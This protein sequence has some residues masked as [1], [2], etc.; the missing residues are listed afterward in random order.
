MAHATR[1]LALLL[2]AVM[3]LGGCSATGLNQ[4]DPSPKLE[5]ASTTTR[6]PANDVLTGK[7]EEAPC[8]VTGFVVARSPQ[9]IVVAGGHLETDPL[10]SDNPHTYGYARGDATT[11][12]FCVF[13]IDGDTPCETEGGDPLPINQVEPGDTVTVRW[14]GPMDYDDPTYRYPERLQI[15]DLVVRLDPQPA[16]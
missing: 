4:A 16:S 10:L 8:V 7:D 12:D 15:P 13:A 2:A 11:P 6:S 1:P 5:A 3:T 9:R 14:T